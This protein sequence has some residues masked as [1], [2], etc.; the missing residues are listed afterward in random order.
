M[1]VLYSKKLINEIITLYGVAIKGKKDNKNF[2]D[3]C[4]VKDSKL[5]RMGISSD[6]VHSIDENGIRHA[7]KHRNISISD[8]LLIPFIITEYDSVKNGNKPN[9]IVYEK[10]FGDTIIYVVEVR[11]G[12]KKLTMKTMYK[13]KL[14][15][16]PKSKL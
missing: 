15:P 13:K 12:R 11:R 16:R 14:K 6:Y 2:I 5:K 7:L 8:F 9:S 4:P 1:P 10:N 3:L